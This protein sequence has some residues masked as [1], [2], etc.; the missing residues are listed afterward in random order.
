MPKFRD[1][2]ASDL[3][4]LFNLDEFA[5]IHNIDGQDI[6]AVLDVDHLKG[7]TRYPEELFHAVN[8]VYISA[9]TLFVRLEDMGER[10]VVG[11]HI[12]VDGE[13]YMVAGCSESMGL[14]EIT[15]EAN[16]A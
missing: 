10:P 2:A 14:L 11:Q 5:E 13:L 9:I 3:N 1:F 7:R 6:P 4:V 16:Q 12:R 8:G 15:L